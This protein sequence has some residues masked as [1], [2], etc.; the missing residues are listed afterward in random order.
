MTIIALYGVIKVTSSL[1]TPFF[2]QILSE[3]CL[4]DLIGIKQPFSYR[5]IYLPRTK[6]II[7]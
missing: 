6:F 2:G 3:G 5:F 1:M 7:T 4:I